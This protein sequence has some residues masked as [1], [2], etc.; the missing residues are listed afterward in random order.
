MAGERTT[1]ASGGR[2]KKKTNEKYRAALAVL[3]KKKVKNGK[4]HLDQILRVFQKPGPDPA[5]ESAFE[6]WGLKKAKDKERE[7]QIEVMWKNFEVILKG[8]QEEASTTFP[9]TPW[10]DLPDP[11][12]QEMISELFRHLFGAAHK[13]A[14][15]ALLA[16]IDN[17]DT[18]W[19]KKKLAKI[20]RNKKPDQKKKAS[21][22]KTAT[23]KKR[24][25]QS[26]KT[27]RIGNIGKTV[28]FSTSS[29]KVLTFSKMDHTVKGRWATRPRFKKKPRRQFLGPDTD[30]ITF[31][32]ELNA[33]H[34]VKPR[35]T[36][37]NIEKL[38]RTGKPQN[39]VIGGKK[40]GR[41]VITEMSEAWERVLNKGEVAKITCDLTLEEY[42]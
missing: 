23:K 3:S 32:V 33:L 21:K 39:V 5:S 16:S 8:V 13:E 17:T 24:P 28:I 35:K 19:A 38:V 2:V 12:K 9:Y 29:K 15:W 31:T 27:G 14:A 10:E 26:S 40:I 1:V 22:K 6:L 30:T 42:L 11:K 20:K 37:R 36:A 7:K 41:Y 34:G 25:K 18:K 4:K